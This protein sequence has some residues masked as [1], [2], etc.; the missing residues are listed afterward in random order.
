MIFG[1]LNVV[2]CP[3][4]AWCNLSCSIFLNFPM[5]HTSSIHS[6]NLGG[7]KYTKI[8]IFSTGCNN[9]DQDPRQASIKQLKALYRQAQSTFPNADIYFP[10]LNFSPYLMLKQQENLQLINKAI[11]TYL[12][13]LTENPYMFQTMDD[14]FHWTAVHIFQH[15]CKQLNLQI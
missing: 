2:F 1:V 11:I 9:K 7:L 4:L 14:H 6:L 12:P 3:I 8:V 10:I 5:H 15:W 13:S